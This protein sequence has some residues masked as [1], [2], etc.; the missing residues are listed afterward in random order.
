MLPNRI[1]LLAAFAG[2]FA[3]PVSSRSVPAHATVAAPMVHISNFTFGP[4]ALKVKVG[5]TV[6]WVNDDDIPHTVVSG[7]RLFKSKVLDTGETFSFTFTK[8]GAYGYFCSLH[9]HMTGKV[10]VSA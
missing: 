9:P 2:A 5:Q 6:T 3:A 10:L 4:Q 7:A 1:V 8:A